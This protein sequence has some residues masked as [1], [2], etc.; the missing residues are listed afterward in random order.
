[1]YSGKVKRKKGG[2]PLE[3]L[4]GGTCLWSK[5]QIWE[6][7]TN[8]SHSKNSGEK[9]SLEAPGLEDPGLGPHG[10]IELEFPG[11]VGMGAKNKEVAKEIQQGSTL[12]MNAP[13][14]N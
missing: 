6:S 10:P 2:M 7:T 5:I 1:M 11:E 14:R 12:R 8:E 9:V 3:V 13:G 4:K